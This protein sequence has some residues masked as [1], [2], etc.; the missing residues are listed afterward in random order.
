MRPTILLFDVDGTLV[1]TGGAGR[2]ALEQVFLHCFGREDAC[3]FALDGMTD[4]AIVRAGLEAIGMQPTEKEIDALLAEYVRILEREVA[5][6]EEARYRLH[7]GIEQALDA[8][9]KADGHALGLG[10]GNIREGARVKLTRVGIYQRFAF[11]GF[12]CDHEDRVE[13]LRCGAQRGAEHLGLSIGECRVVV[14]GDTPK[15][16]AAAHGIG[17]E[18]IGVGTGRFTPSEL[19]AAG[20]TAAFPN[21]AASGALEALLVSTQ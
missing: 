20:A 2:R 3:P 19:L 7:L 15:D 17:A 6:V 16:V 1:T 9:S 11:G 14:I 12:G 21:L 10:T 13:L 4:R 5:G 18:S 8:A